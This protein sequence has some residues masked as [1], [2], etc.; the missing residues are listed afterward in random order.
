[1]NHKNKS[2]WSQS[3]EH[4][5]EN[6]RKGNPDIIYQEWT[7]NLMDLMWGIDCL[8]QAQFGPLYEEYILGGR[9]LT[10]PAMHLDRGW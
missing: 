3:N 2:K 9:S 7:S 6:Y 10:Q 1:M 8:I 4:F 5:L